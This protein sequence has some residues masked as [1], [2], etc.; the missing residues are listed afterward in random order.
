[1]AEELYFR[2]YLLPR[3]TRLRGWAPA[4]NSVLFALYHLWTPWQIVSRAVFYFPTVYAVWRK[5]NIFIAIWVHCLG[6]TLGALLSL[7][8]ATLRP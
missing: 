6:N 2:G 5:R 7:A 8:A 4:V 3:M 1:M